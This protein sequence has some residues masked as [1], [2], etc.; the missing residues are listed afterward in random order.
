MNPEQQSAAHADLNYPLCVVAGPGSGKTYTLIERIKY[1]ARTD[2]HASILVL[3]FSKTAV[4]EMQARLA[5]EGCEM[6]RINVATFHSFGFKIVTTFHKQMGFERLPSKMSSKQSNDILKESLDVA[7]DMLLAYNASENKVAFLRKLLKVIQFAN[8]KS[9][10]SS[11]LAQ[12]ASHDLQECRQIANIFQAYQQ[13]LKSRAL[14][15][16]PDMVNLPQSL[17]AQCLAR[18]ATSCGSDALSFIQ[19]QYKY[20]VVDEFQDLNGAQLQ[21]LLQVGVHGH[22]TVVGDFD[23]VKHIILCLLHYFFNINSY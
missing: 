10:P 7:P 13:K 17:F 6:S 14:F 5:K 4:T 8:C 1:V 3:A 22:V 23:Q 15:D 9:N 18:Q 16:F 21:L 20:I 2:V 12:N 19:E 11:Y